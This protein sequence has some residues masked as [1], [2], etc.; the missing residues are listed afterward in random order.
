M[1]KGYKKIRKADVL[2]VDDDEGRKFMWD[3]ENF[4]E[5]VAPKI[6]KNGK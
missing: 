4:Y 3:G 1:K 2:L 5:L 6:K